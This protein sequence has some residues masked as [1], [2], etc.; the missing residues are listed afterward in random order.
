MKMIIRNASL[1]RA[2]ARSRL[3]ERLMAIALTGR[4]LKMCFQTDFLN[5]TIYFDKDIYYISKMVSM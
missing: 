3:M 4:V 5:F 2:Q 1:V